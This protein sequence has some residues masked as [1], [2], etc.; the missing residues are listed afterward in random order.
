MIQTWAGL[1]LQVLE[2]HPALKQR[3]DWA[4]ENLTNL[5]QGSIGRGRATQ[6]STRPVVVVLGAWVPLGG[7]VRRQLAHSDSTRAEFAE[8]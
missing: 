5:V 3:M 1:P 2:I 8:A 4:K 7:R 6:S